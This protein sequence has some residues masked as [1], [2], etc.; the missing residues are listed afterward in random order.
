MF[1]HYGLIL[2]ILALG[3]CHSETSNEASPVSPPSAVPKE[4]ALS[5]QEASPSSE[6]LA[7][8]RTAALNQMG[9][10]ILKA[11]RQTGGL[12]FESPTWSKLSKQYSFGEETTLDV[13]GDTGISPIE[14]GSVVASFYGVDQSVEV[15]YPELLAI[16]K[17]H[18]L[19][20]VIGEHVGQP[21]QANLATMTT[22][23]V[24]VETVSSPLT[25]AERQGLEQWFLSW[26]AQ[27][28]F[29][30]G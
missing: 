26:R 25:L 10:N 21:N 23:V 13:F 11:T 27:K 12:S 3:A 1:K 17:N 29:G 14:G 7:K 6:E 8:I 30:A 4:P 2:A 15:A 5:K 22:P 19:V 18:Q 16:F 28:N 20:A 24:Y 9:Q